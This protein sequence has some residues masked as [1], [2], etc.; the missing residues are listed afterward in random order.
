MATTVTKKATDKSAEKLKAE[1]LG[2][3]MENEAVAAVYEQLQENYVADNLNTALES[4][5][6]NYSDAVI[7]KAIAKAVNIKIS[8]LKIAK[9]K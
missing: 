6:E 2:L 3:K 1:K 7:I 4:V 8:E 5:R 9:K